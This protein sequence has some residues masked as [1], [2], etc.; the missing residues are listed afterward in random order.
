MALRPAHLLP[1]K[2]LLTPRLARR[3]SPTNRGLLPG[4]P[5]PTGTGLSPAS[6]IQLSGHTT[7]LLYAPAP[8]R[9]SLC[10][11]RPRLARTR[12]RT[13]RRRAELTGADAVDRHVHRGF[14]RAR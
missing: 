5:V 8:T 10:R 11:T 3:I 9:V 6:L 14:F 2:R 1:P 12:R 7:A 13:G 4:A